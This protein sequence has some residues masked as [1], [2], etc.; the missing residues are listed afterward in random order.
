MYLFFFIL[1]YIIMSIENLSSISEYSSYNDNNGERFKSF[2]KAFVTVLAIHSHL[3]SFLRK[4]KS[5][6]DAVARI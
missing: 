6:S 5:N 3:I 4:I 1:K 2:Q